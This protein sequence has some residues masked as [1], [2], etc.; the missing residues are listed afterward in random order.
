MATPIIILNTSTGSDSLASGAGPGD[1]TTSGSAITGTKGRTDGR[2]S[3]WQRVGFFE[4]SQPD[5]TGVL[6]DGSHALYIASAT[7]TEQN[8]MAITLVKNT[9]QTGSFTSTATVANVVVDDSTK[10]SVGDVINLPGAGATAGT[11]DYHLVTVLVDPTTITVSP[12]PANTV[13]ATY[14]NPCQ[15]GFATTLNT[16]LSAD[17]SWAIGGKRLTISGTASRKLFENNAAAGD[18]LA[19][20]TM[21]MESAFTDTL[22]ST[23]TLRRSGDA[24]SGPI[25]LKGTDGAA[26][27][28]ILTFSNNGNC[29]IM[30]SSIVGI[31]F[32]NFEMVNTNATKTASVGITVGSSGVGL[33]K[34]VKISNST[35]KFWKGILNSGSASVDDCEIGFTASNAIESSSSI[36]VIGC[37]IHDM[38]GFGINHTGTSFLIINNIIEAGASDGIR[39]ADTTTGGAPTKHIIGNTI[40]GNTGD[41][42]EVSSTAA[43]TNVYRSLLFMNNNLTSNASGFNFSGA[44]VTTEFLKIVFTFMRN[45]NLNG[46]TNRVL[47][48]SGITFQEEDDVNVS[49]SYEDS[50]NG[51]FEVGVSLKSLGFPLAVY[52]G[53]LTLSY[54]DIGAAQR[55]EFGVILYDT[56]LYDTTIN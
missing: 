8:F 27:K 43:Q 34:K 2:T 31:V 7:A 42:I 36:R 22:A 19:G 6:T 24:T 51:N 20:W 40:H 9:Q 44:S 15:V 35:N 55:A 41:G 56:T 38:T 39:L 54:V 5:L 37:Y 1:G 29:L 49:P 23:L 50:A 28:P 16:V 4:A 14:V 46:N 32:L 47:P 12:I 30:A 26:T 17:T 25:T 52:P 53:S 3:L 18:A 45:N 33:I 11:P 48:S 21:Q 13:T 10:F